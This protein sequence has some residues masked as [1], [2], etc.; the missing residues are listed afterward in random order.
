[1]KH[2]SLMV[3][4]LLATGVVFTSARCAGST[5]RPNVILILTD[6]QGYGDREMT[7]KTS[8]DAMSVDFTVSLNKG[9]QPRLQ[10]S[11]HDQAGKDLGGSHFV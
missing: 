7:K 11:F 6:D 2:T 4:W 9:D 10:S 5:D 3:L 1:M 8:P